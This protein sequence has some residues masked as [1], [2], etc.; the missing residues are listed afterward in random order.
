MANV[1][2]SLEF[3]YE[4]GYYRIQPVKLLNRSEI[5]L[6]LNLII[7]KILKGDTPFNVLWLYYDLM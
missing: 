1:N 6:I 2:I 7:K 4:R 5:T 3:T